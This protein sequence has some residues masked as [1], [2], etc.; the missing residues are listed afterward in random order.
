MYIVLTANPKLWNAD[1]AP[2]L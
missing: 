2:L 1:K